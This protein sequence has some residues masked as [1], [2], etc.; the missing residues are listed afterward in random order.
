MKPERMGVISGQQA[1]SSSK[2][3]ILVVDDNSKNLL[4]L[5][6]TLAS[7]DRDLVLAASGEEA[8]KILLN[9]EIAVVVLDVQ[10]AGID[11]YETAVLIRSREK[12]RD[13][14]I[15]FV[16]SYNK[17]ETDVVRGY[18]HGAVDY[19]F[20]PVV[21]EILRCKIN[22]FLELYKRTQEL[23]TRNEELER[24]EKE[25]L[26]TKA[27]ESLIK[28]APDPVFLSD[29]RG[30]I[31]QVND[32]VS[33]L[34]GLRAEDV[35]E[36]SLA[37]FLSPEER[38]KFAHALREVVEQG[39]T[40]NVRLNSRNAAGRITPTMLNASALRDPEGHVIGTIG[41]LRDMT[42]YDAMVRDLERSQSTL[43]EKVRELEQF[44]EVVVGRELKMIA[45]EKELAKFKKGASSGERPTGAGGPAP[46]DG[47]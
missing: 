30:K 24:A 22:V 3:V 16:T 15:I 12:T 37:E 18:E 20:K 33:D 38:R 39:V 29:L 36:Q 32:A 1:G 35:V 6:A 17:D 25:L 26:R 31:L 44:E 10:M 7:D 47:T 45:L 8:L 34:L 43:M 14:P 2:P 46:V 23:K 42:A 9:Q 28:Y 5:E 13:V 40:R 21:P 27:A 4:A 11:G 41:I 19:I